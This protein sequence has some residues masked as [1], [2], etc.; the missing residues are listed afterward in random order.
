MFLKRLSHDYTSL[1]YMGMVSAQCITKKGSRLLC[2]R[3]A[4]FS[5]S[6]QM[7]FLFGCWGIVASATLAAFVCRLGYPTNQ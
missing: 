2:Y 3:G 5:G 7:H 4:L 6:L 1:E